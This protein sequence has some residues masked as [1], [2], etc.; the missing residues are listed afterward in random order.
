MAV[1]ILRSRGALICAASA[2][3]L[4]LTALVG[5]PPLAG[6]SGLRTGC[7]R[8]RPALAYRLGGQVVRPQPAGAPVP[9]LE[10]VDQRTSESADVDVLA[11]GEIL[12]APLVEN[13]YPAPLDDR[14]PAEIAVSSTGGRS[15][16]AIV[17]GDT[18]HILDVPPWMSVD[19][20]TQRVW[21]ASVL[22]DLCGAE[23]SWSDDAGR[24]WQTNPAVGC[25]AMGSESVLEGRAP[26][27]G[28][29][30][31]GY[32]HVVYYCANL[33]DLSPSNLWCYRSLDGGSSFSFTGSFSDPPPKPGC[34]TE[35]PARPGAVGPEGYL[36]FPIF[37]CGALSMA[38]SRDEGASWH[39]VPIGTYAVQDMYTTSVAVDPA[40]NLY[41]AWIEG[42]PGASTPPA[43]G[44]PNPATEAIDGAGVP[45]LAISRDH[46]A[47]WSRPVEVGPP[48]IRNAQMIAIAAHRV[49]QIAISYLASAHGGE[50][51]DGWLSE[52]GNA[53]AARAL[54]WAAPLN[55][56]AT[57][58]IDTRNSTGFGNRLFFNTDSFAP[59][60][61][62]WAAFHC[63]FTAA[64]P[65]ERIGVV[66]RLLPSGGRP[67]HRQHPNRPR[68]KRRH[69]HN[70]HRRVA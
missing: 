70:I 55:D 3:T 25:P 11:S 47:T 8:S 38:V 18:N 68:R 46:G 13:T 7:D 61:V 10:V 66:G 20:Q 15:W 58:L 43:G 28:A 67:A 52:T 50:L 24:T 26:P 2:M 41:L 17:P 12:Y 4:A 45:M 44:G 59:D 62:P 36:Y 1:V 6:A 30:P 34:N 53:L 23:I 48:G 5:M 29:E 39:R 51:L 65:N 49:G 42:L 37:Q 21:F 33:S 31:S 56:P 16:R 69:G 54:W 22:P 19:P 35:H 14:G 57:P 9:C 60:G 63:A 40:G 32:P 64:C 27:G